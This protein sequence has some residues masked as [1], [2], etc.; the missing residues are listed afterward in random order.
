ME[1]TGDAAGIVHAVSPKIVTLPEFAQPTRLKAVKVV[2]FKAGTMHL[3]GEFEMLDPVMVMTWSPG[4][5]LLQSASSKS[6]TTKADDIAICPATLTRPLN[7]NS[8][9][10]V[11]LDEK[12]IKSV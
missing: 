5:T 10:V 7:L 2:V 6:V 12:E 3:L 4:K 11:L 9:I 8:F 1:V